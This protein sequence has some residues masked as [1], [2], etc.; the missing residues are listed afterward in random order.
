MLVPKRVVSTLLSLLLV[1]A[2]PATAAAGELFSVNSILDEPDKN[3][4]AEGCKTASNAC[5]LRAAI[6]ESN[7]SGGVR[8]AILFDNTVFQ[9]EAAG[10]TVV[11]SG[12]FPEIKDPVTIDANSGSGCL[13][14]SGFTGPC[15]GLRRSDTGNGLVVNADEVTIEGLSVTSTSTAINVINESTDFIAKGD[16]IGINLKGEAI[17]NNTGIFI[18][19]GSD[20]AAIGGVEEEDR[21]VIAGN[22]GVGLDIEGASNATVNGNYFGVGPS[23]TTQKANA[24]DIEVTN[25]TAGGG[26][27]AENNEI[28]TVPSME[29]QLTTKCDGGCNVI[30]GALATGVDLNGEG[31][32]FNEA[33]AS[34][35]TL[36]QSNFIGIGGNGFASVPNGTYGVLAGGADEATVGGSGNGKLN[37]IDG[38]SYGV[39]GENGDDLQVLGNVIG[40]DRSGGVNTPPSSVAIFAFSLSVSSPEAGARIAGNSIAMTGG[41]GIEQRF[42]G[43]EIENNFIEGGLTGILTLGSSVGEGNLISGNRVHE[44]AGNG[45]LVENDSNLVTGNEVLEPGEAGILVKYAGSFPLA[46]GTTGNVVGGEE[47]FEEN[48]IVFAGGPAIEIKDFEETNNEVTRNRGEGNSGLFI[49]LVSA[50]FSE[51]NG[52][53]EGIKPP[54]LLT[55]FQSKSSGTAQPGATVRIFRKASSETGELASFLGEAKADG[56]GNW[57]V[58]YGAVPTGT[59]LAATQTST[60]GGTSELATAT[61]VAEPSGGG[62]GGN[63]GG[64][65]GGGGGNGGNKDT[66]PPDTKILKGP[67]K[68]THKTTVKFKFSSSEANSSFECKLDHKPFKKCS[69]PKKYKK[70][71]PGKHVFKVRAI[72]KAGNVDPTPAKRK[73]TVLK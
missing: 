54:A 2:F 1:L 52:P 35:P 27:K 59:I 18:D 14:E 44:V 72:D 3:L 50:Q 6:E 57:T 32:G 66:I 34:G 41:T 70:L 71:K 26:F 12:S 55:A 30:S 38:G 28:G 31:G 67:P 13:N 36:V 23:G 49:D 40:R 20:G 53:N 58:S 5:T 11:I 24:K 10:D 21:N 15:A 19:P 29:A 45:I 73:F 37:Y 63:G 68:K 48:E 17:A 64:N 33:P 39:Y 46:V 8:D 56:S 61:A 51:P 25:S 16:W 7:N 47:E 60:K 43:A 62:G 9:G 4:G 65:N 69:S 42:T 22:V